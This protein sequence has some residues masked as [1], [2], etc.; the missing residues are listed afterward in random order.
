MST[1]SKPTSHDLVVAPDGSIP[2]DQLE[3][4]G[5]SPGTHLRV[6]QT[7]QRGTLAG[8]LPDLPDLTWEEFEQASALARHDLTAT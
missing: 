6:V 5:V 2:A 3:R 7:S 4:L 1:A 8:S